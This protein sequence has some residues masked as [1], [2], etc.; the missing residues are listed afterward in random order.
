MAS[1]DKSPFLAFFY[2][3][4]RWAV[5]I[6]VMVLNLSVLMTKSA[7]FGFGYFYGVIMMEG[8]SKKLPIRVSCPILLG[9][10][11]IG[12]INLALY[13]NSMLYIL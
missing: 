13:N 8:S 4:P 11:G 5:S 12:V 7:M 10:R 1:A 9:L 3:S 2:V 6:F